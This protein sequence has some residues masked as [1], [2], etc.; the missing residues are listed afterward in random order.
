MIDTYLADN[1]VF[2]A[3]TFIN[4]IR[5]HAQRLR[6][7]GVNA[8]HQNGTAER[9]IKTVSDMSRAMML[10]ASVHWKD[11]IDSSLWPMTTTYAAYIYN[12]FP[13]AH[14]IAPADLFSGTQFPRHKL[15]DIHTW[16]CPVYVLD[17]TL[18]RGKKLPKWQPRSRKGI[19]V[20]FS[21][22]HGSEVPLILNPN[23]GHISPQFHVVFDDSFSTVCSQLDSDT[24][25]S[26]WNEF[27]LDEFLYQ[28]PLD[29]DTTT[30]LADEWLTPQEREEKERTRVR[31][32][33]LRSLGQTVI[34]PSTGTSTSTALR[35]LPESISS[36]KEPKYVDAVEFVSDLPLILPQPSPI[37]SP[38]PSP[39]PVLR[40][41]NRANLRQRTEPMFQHEVFNASLQTPSCS[42]QH[43]TL[44]YHAALHTDYDTGLF[45]GT[46][47]RAYA[48]GHKLHDPDQ[49]SL[50]E[51]LH[52][53]ASHHYI[54]AM[55]L[56]IA[57]LMKQKTWE[58]INIADI[59]KDSNGNSRKVL[60]GTWALK[61]KRLPDGTPSKYKA[62][63]CVRGDLQTEGVD[64]FKHMLQWFNGQL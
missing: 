15:K 18:Q 30:T 35:L 51:A 6:F 9:A 16:G 53:E 52:G 39:A 17:P 31:A 26:F 59:P 2:K 29:A 7:C 61:L 56:E 34:P 27:D 37:P 47:A 44:A 8:H 21:S 40:R 19:F 58:R 62:R 12:H 36:S 42:Y 48:A 54:E 5:D 3:N 1:G 4:H 11:G 43:Q 49:P 14:G 20:G 64:F 28:I 25:P 41:S 38:L 57:Q 33:Q 46:D 60:K 45:N 63:Y 50:H 10:H 32:L 13:D 24:P 55:K 23:T 22:S